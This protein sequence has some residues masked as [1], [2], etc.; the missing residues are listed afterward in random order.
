M[1][2]RV[3]S[4]ALVLSLLPLG[5]AAAQDSVL[6]QT[7]SA[8]AI[9]E[10]KPK[11]REVPLTLREAVVLGLERNPALAVERAR[12]DEA[13]ERISEE[14]GIFDPVVSV[15]STA[16]RR[17]NI[18]A[19]R[20]YPTGLYVDHQQGSRVGIESKTLFGGKLNLGLDYQRLAST[21]NTQTLSPQ[22]SA[23]FLFGVTQPLLR[24][25]G[26]EATMARIRVA[27]KQSEIA[28]QSLS[29]RVAEIVEHIE[30]AYWTFVFSQ[31]Q[32]KTRQRGLDAERGFLKQA[33]LLLRADRVTQTS[34]L[35]VGVG[36]A[37]REG[38]IIAAEAETDR[39]EDGLKV[40]LQL[41]L[42]YAVTPLDDFDSSE[43]PDA[44][45]SVEIALA[46]RPE[47]VAQQRELEQRQIE[48]KLAKNQRLPRLDL[49]AQYTSS[50]LAG[51]PSPTCID[52]TVATCVPVGTSVPDSIFVDRTRP[53]DALSGLILRHP[54]DGWTAEL[55]MEMPIMNRTAN[56]Q[57]SEAGLRVVEARERLQ[58]SRDQVEQEIRTALR[59][60][61]AAQRRAQVAHNAASVVAAQLRD[62][63]RQFEARLI[64]GYDV[65]RTRDELDK[66]NSLELKALMDYNIALSRARLADMTILDRYNIELAGSRD[67]ASR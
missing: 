46:R 8:Q 54:F 4:I 1:R 47:I 59:D 52:P 49:T 26:R 28:Q 5:R 55:K 66:A 41:D 51:Q 65:S 21:S 16:G 17:D 33:E 36:V 43:T 58:A 39:T 40:L 20:F 23:N 30:E 14:R 35:Q 32:L 38:D 42:S 12:A 50:G 64:S 48:L 57:Y 25:F 7:L 13:R 11:A 3:F 29:R 34:V 37:Q 24:D 45:K 44:D 63:G 2:V 15:S 53:I 62:M 19:S 6:P 61:Q 22:Y 60:A 56:A 18:V 9:T 27:A 31:Q 67:A 10:L